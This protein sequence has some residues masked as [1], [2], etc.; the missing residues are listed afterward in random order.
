MFHFIVI[1]NGSFVIKIYLSGF[2]HSGP[3][4]ELKH[5]SYLQANE[6]DVVRSAQTPKIKLNNYRSIG[7]VG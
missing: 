7:E 3:Q 6:D 5:I 4:F 1:A 2:S